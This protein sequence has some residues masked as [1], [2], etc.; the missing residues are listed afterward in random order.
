MVAF[1]LA[2]FVFLW[3]AD[4]NE[5]L[6]KVTDADWEYIGYQER[7]PRPAAGRFLRR[8]V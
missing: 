2:P 1:I 7:P 4:N 8:D 5:F 6:E 3:T